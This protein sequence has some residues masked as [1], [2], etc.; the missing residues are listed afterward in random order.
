MINCVFCS[1]TNTDDE[2]LGRCIVCWC[3]CVYDQTLLIKITIIHFMMG[4]IMDLFFCCGCSCIG[5]RIWSHGVNTFWSL[6][7]LLLPLW[8]YTSLHAIMLIVC[9]SFNGVRLSLLVWVC[10]WI[11]ANKVNNHS[12]YCYRRDQSNQRPNM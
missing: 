10:V 5:N 12:F 7:D 3:A 8:I 4:I 1:A 11:F 6:W 9:H 2:W